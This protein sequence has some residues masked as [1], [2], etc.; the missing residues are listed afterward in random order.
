MVPFTL[1]FDIQINNII[2]QDY[3]EAIASN[4]SG[5]VCKSKT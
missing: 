5:G 1:V 2:L 3:V 4:N